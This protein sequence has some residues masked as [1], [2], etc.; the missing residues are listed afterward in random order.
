MSLSTQ[1]HVREL[2][3]ETA[4][5]E[6]QGKVDA[7]NGIVRGEVAKE[8]ECVALTAVWRAA[9]VEARYGS[10]CGDQGHET[11]VRDANKLL[12]KVRKAMGFTYPEKGTI[13]V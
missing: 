10:G 2:L 1:D 5:V 11:A 3:Y 7:M 12:V 8:L 4:P 13:N 9:Y 6:L